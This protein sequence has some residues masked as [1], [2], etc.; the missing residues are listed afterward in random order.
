MFRKCGACFVGCLFFIFLTVVSLVSLVWIDENLFHQ[1]NN[2]CFHGGTLFVL[3]PEGV[4]KTDSN[5]FSMASLP[6]FIQNK[7]LHNLGFLSDSVFFV[8]SKGWGFVQS[9]GQIQEMRDSPVIVEKIIKGREES[10]WLCG[11][12]STTILTV[13]S[14][15]GVFI[16]NA[17]NLPS[18][19]LSI[20]FVKDQVWFGTLSGLFGKINSGWKKYGL[21]E[22]LCDGSV[23][24]M[25]P[26][27]SR[28]WVLVPPFHFYNSAGPPG[29]YKFEMEA[30]RF[31][32][33]SLPK[34]LSGK[35]VLHAVDFEPFGIAMILAVD[36]GAR[37]GNDFAFFSPDTGKGSIEERIPF[38]CRYLVSDGENLYGWHPNNRKIAHW[39]PNF[40]KWGLFDF[41]SVPQLK[42]SYRLR[43]YKT[44]VNLCLAWGLV[45]IFL[46]VWRLAMLKQKRSKAPLP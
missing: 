21:P 3:T 45:F 17:G 18:G 26:T 34:E 41:D 42:E 5:G 24:F 7:N 29:L 39:E 10:L 6:A 35:V 27:A 14:K 31:S 15:K 20:G 9:N 25:V 40:K 23:E 33:Q 44:F 8:D 4:G 37:E 22:G 2:V 38:P 28:M 43:I 32:Y 46:Y 19:T 12:A 30:G 16:S 1:I 11:P 13:D 36:N